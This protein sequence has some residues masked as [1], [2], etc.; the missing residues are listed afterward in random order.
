MVGLHQPFALPYQGCDDLDLQRLYGSL[1]CRIM[2]DHYP[3]AVMP[4]RAAHPTSRVSC[5]SSAASFRPTRIGRLPLQGWL[6]Q[7]DRRRF[8]VFGYYTRT[9]RDFITEA[10]ASLCDRFV[11]G[12]TSTDDWR[13]AILF[14]RPHVLIYPEVGMDAFTARLAA[15]RL[16]PVQCTSWG[17]PITSGFPSLDYYLEQRPDRNRPARARSIPSSSV[18]GSR[19]CRSTT[20]RS[21]WSRRI[22]AR[23]TLACAPT[24]RVLV[25]S[26]LEQ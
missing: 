13:E 25:R 21:P 22:D 2:A 20:S 14:R 7:L 9:R 26:G 18:A 12:H 15:Q 5:K 19:I 3:P 11:H 8:R 10:A 16:A 4:A 1:I 24:R 17:H 23:A 6:T